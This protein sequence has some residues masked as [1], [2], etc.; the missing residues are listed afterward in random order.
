MSQ[1]SLK[2]NKQFIVDLISFLDKYLP[3][4][5]EIRNQL[6]SIVLAYLKSHDLII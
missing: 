2:E 6:A 1:V 3:E 4:N 5:D